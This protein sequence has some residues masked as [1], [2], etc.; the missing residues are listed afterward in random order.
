MIEAI[1]AL[2]TQLFL[3]LNGLHQPWLDQLMFVMTED[4]FWI[5]AYLLMLWMIYKSHGAKPA[6]WSLLGVALVITLGD[7]ISVELFK[8]VFQRYR[9]THN[10]NI[11]HLVHTVNDYRGGKF[12]FVS[13]HATNAAG[14][15]TF[16]YL[17]VYK[18]FAK[19][20]WW[21]LL[22]AALFSYTRIYLGVHYPADVVCG[23]ILGAGIGYGV[24]LAF[25][26]WVPG[27]RTQGVKIH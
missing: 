11:G 25:R 27:Y 24:Y 10:L 4:V 17:L 15:A 14:V 19:W 6:L 21:I 12:G 5:P 3:R 8:E 20:A 1:K 7:R 26:K 22:W 16:V 2:D 13:S 23:W 18:A 9:P